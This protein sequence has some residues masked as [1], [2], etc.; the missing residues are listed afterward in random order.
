M[1]LIN[2]NLSKFNETYLAMKTNYVHR[3]S[4]DMLQESAQIN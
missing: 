1:G 2:N 4:L 3:Y